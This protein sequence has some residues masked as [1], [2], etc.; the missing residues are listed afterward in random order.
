MRREPGSG[1][2]DPEPSKIHKTQ[3]ANIFGSGR[4]PDPRIGLKIMQMSPDSDPQIQIQEFLCGPQICIGSVPY[5]TDPLLRIQLGCKQSSCVKGTYF[6]A[7]GGPEIPYP[8][9][10]WIMV[11]L[12]GS[13]SPEWVRIGWSCQ[14]KPANSFR[15]RHQNASDACWTINAVS[16]RFFIFR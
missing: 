7:S 10:S 4:D 16:P 13:R 14:L 3:N 1:S 5:R 9:F 15:G 12:R 6:K 8:E 2:P 11:L